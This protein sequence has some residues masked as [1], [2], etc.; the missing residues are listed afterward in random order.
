MKKK[1]ERY[2]WQGSGIAPLMPRDKA[3][4]SAPSKAQKSGRVKAG[5]LPPVRRSKS[6]FVCRRLGGVKAGLFVAG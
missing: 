1:G 5:F 3:I 4:E 6:W 2:D